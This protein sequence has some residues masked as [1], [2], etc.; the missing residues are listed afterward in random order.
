MAN[1]LTLSLI[2]PP[3]R[4]E[5]L[6]G[7]NKACFRG[8]VSSWQALPVCWNPKLAAI[9][10][11]FHGNGKLKEGDWQFRDRRSEGFYGRCDGVCGVSFRARA[12]IPNIL[13]TLNIL[14]AIMSPGAS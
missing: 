4:F 7:G 12:N 2:L 10:R 8:S 14:G 11:R 6:D 9:L 3:V 13:G 5:M 1:A